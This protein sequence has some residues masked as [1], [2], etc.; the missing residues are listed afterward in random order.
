MVF[1]SVDMHL[2]PYTIVCATQFFEF[3]SAIADADTDDTRTNLL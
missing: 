1:L 2:Q 3:L